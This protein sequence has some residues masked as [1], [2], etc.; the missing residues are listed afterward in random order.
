MKLSPIH[1]AATLALFALLMWIRMQHVLNDSQV[2]LSLTVVAACALGMLAVIKPSPVMFGVL[3]SILGIHLFY[4]GVVLVLKLTGGVDVRLISLSG[5]VL[6]LF[7]IASA[8]A[9]DVRQ[10]YF[11]AAA[12]PSGE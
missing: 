11:G 2:A 8:F 7:A 9:P 1:I 6:N 10:R 3:L 5:G 12:S 4:A